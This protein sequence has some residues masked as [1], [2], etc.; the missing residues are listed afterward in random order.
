MQQRVLCLA[1][2]ISLFSR[3]FYSNLY[4]P[5]LVFSIFFLWREKSAHSVAR[6]L[7]LCI[8]FLF[9]IPC[10]NFCLDGKMQQRVLGTT[11][12][13]TC[14]TAVIFV[15]LILG[16]SDCVTVP[17]SRKGRGLSL[18]MIGASTIGQCPI[19]SGTLLLPP[20]RGRDGGSNDQIRGW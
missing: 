12:T 5:R 15:A 4:I 20:P 16:W 6:P 2:S 9:Q 17:L 14:P 3:R 19:H 13:V 7:S 18:C 10:G 1:N 11:G 8:F